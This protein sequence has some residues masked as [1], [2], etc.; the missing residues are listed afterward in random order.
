MTFTQVHMLVVSAGLEPTQRTYQSEGWRQKLD[1][2][3][4][5]LFHFLD[6]SWVLWKALSLILISI[7]MRQ[8]AVP[9]FFYCLYILFS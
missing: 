7:C 2:R 1:Q 3:N 5:G 4:L 6:G 9:P 8:I